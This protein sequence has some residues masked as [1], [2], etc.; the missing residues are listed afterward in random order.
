MKTMSKGTKV[1]PMTLKG[2]QVFAHLFQSG[3]GSSFSG[4]RIAAVARLRQESDPKDRFRLVGLE[5]S[6]PGQALTHTWKGPSPPF[7]TVSE[8]HPKM[9]KVCCELPSWLL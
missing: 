7:S 1:K 9:H 3:P 2:T 8:S 6:A 5:S 4:K